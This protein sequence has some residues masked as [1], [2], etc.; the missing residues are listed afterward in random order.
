MPIVIKKHANAFKRNVVIV[1]RR[2]VWST[3]GIASPSSATTT[4]AAERQI[5]DATSLY[6]NYVASGS[7]TDYT[8]FIT[9]Y[10]KSYINKYNSALNKKEDS[11]ALLDFNS[12]LKNKGMLN[13]VAPVCD[14]MLCD[15]YRKA[16]KN[17]ATGN[18][19]GILNS[20]D[21]CAKMNYK[22]SVAGANGLP[23]NN[24]INVF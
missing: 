7:L 11:T 20:T 13:S 6:S 15:F 2:K 1:K 19:M 12:R 14:N 8:A 22:A 23:Y 17:S 3:T 5:Y 16:S 18:Y 24:L 9:S 21:E 10:N 4:V